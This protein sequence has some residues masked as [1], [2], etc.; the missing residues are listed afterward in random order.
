MIPLSGRDSPSAIATPVHRPIRSLGDNAPVRSIPRSQCPPRPARVHPA[1]DKGSSREDPKI[2]YPDSW[3][4]HRHSRRVTRPNSPNGSLHSCRLVRDVAAF[5]HPSGS[6]GFARNTP[7][8][9]I[10]WPTTMPARAAKQA[11]VGED[12]AAL[13]AAAGEHNAT[14]PPDSR[15]THTIPAL[16]CALTLA[17]AVVVAIAGAS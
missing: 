13:G 15:R 5:G 10:L 17:N 2:C 6:D 16:S 14:R 8:A 9:S 3:H 4:D 7:A 1:V 11:A 12:T